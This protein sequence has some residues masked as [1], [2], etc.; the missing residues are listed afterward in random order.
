MCL[1]EGHNAV[2]PV[3]LEPA[4][5]QS[6]VKRSTTEPQHLL[7]HSIQ[8]VTHYTEKGHWPK[9]DM[10]TILHISEFAGGKMLNQNWTCTRSILTKQMIGPL[11]GFEL[12]VKFLLN[13][14]DDFFN[15]LYTREMFNQSTSI[16]HEVTDFEKELR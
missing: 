10:Q 15:C 2:T 12:F 6:R 4:A 14:I 7:L 3:R 11:W 1:A 5:L 16:V 8:Y 9:C 13:R